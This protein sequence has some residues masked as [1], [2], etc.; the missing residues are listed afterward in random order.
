GADRAGGAGG[1][2]PRLC[3]LRG[4]R[5][6]QLDHQIILLDRHRK[7]LGHVRSL[8][9]LGAGLD[10]HLV[11]AR[12]HRLRVAPRLAGA[13]V[14]LPAMPGAAQELAPARQAIVAGAIR[15]HERADLAEAQRAAGVR[16]AVGERKEFAVEIED[17]DLAS[18]DADDPAGAGRD[19][20]GP[21]D[22]LPAHGR[23]YSALAFSSSTRALSASDALNRNT[24]CGSS[25]SQCG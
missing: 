10:R 8:D 13:D 6:R 12:A 18:A 7:R 4:G 24:C 14:V 2:G 11:L 19:I 25:K 23:P 9:Q 5:R 16:A 22:D 3:G 20:A 15:Q 21:R 17:A 1:A